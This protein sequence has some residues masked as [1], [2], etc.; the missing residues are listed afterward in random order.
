[1]AKSESN[2][3]TSGPIAKQIIMFALPIL[4]GNVFQ[5]LYN[6]VDSIVVG[7]IEGLTALAAVS[8]SF[9]ITNLITGFFV[10][11]STGAS[12]LFSRYF[13]KG[14]Y[15][16]LHDAIHTI[17]LLSFI[18]GILLV[19]GGL[20]SSP[21][22]LNIVNC[23]LD[24]FAQADTYLRVYFIGILFTCLYNVSS[25]VL[26]AVG[27]SRNP[28]IFLMIACITNIVLDVIFVGPFHMGVFGAG[29]A[30]VI[31]QGLSFLLVLV[32]LMRVDDVYR[33]DLRHLYLDKEI[34]KE[35]IR[36]GVPAGL[37]MIVVSFS[38][39]FVQSY[40]NSFGSAAIAGMG[41]ARKVQGYVTMFDQA[42]CLSIT[43]FVS[44]NI[45][46]NNVKRA[47]EGIRK[48]LLLDIICVMSIG[49]ITFIFAQ[50]FV[51]LFTNDQS[52]FPYGITLI[53]IYSPLY[54]FIIINDVY[55][56]SLRGFGK[57]GVVMCISVLGMVIIRQ[58]F[59][60]IA[61]GINYDVHIV[62]FSYPV[63]WFFSAL[64]VYLYY[65]LF[66]R[67]NYAHLK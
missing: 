42:L 9:D 19:I 61:M 28:F 47:F 59:L 24:V 64:F 53:R 38:N 35:T 4:L 17:L 10:G 3:F 57:S 7:Q 40:A 66:V 12:I 65:R 54:I 60:A 2:L 45:G 21:Y 31:S 67:H 22:L 30:T 6:S 43:T 39:L 27:D 32:K 14:N 16:R 50:F 52:A 11:F 46:A 34:I 51:S 5:N 25:S 33:V 8:A 18:I 49:A 13:G 62:Y 37:Q 23:P 56:Y 48:C 29:L 15:Q 55:A 44:Q 63:G 58:I 41:A 36:L 1:M 26:R 20:V